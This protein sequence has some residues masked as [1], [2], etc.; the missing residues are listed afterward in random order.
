MYAR[1]SVRF[2]SPHGNFLDDDR[3]AVAANDAPHGVKQ[4]DQK[5]PER[6]E[7]ETA[8]GELIVTGRRLMAA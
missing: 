7:L 1:V 8:L 4:K 5:P 2:P 3:L 6:N